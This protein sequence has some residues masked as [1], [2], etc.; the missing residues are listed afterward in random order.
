MAENGKIKTTIYQKC[1]KFGDL[2][3]LNL[4]FVVSCVPIITIGAATTAMYSFTTKLVKDVEGP[5]WKSYWSAFRK[6]FKAATKAWLVVLVILVAMFLEFMVSYSTAGLAYAF[7]LALMALEAVFLSFV[8][9]LLFPLIARYKNTTGNYFKNAFLLCISNIGSW[10]YLFFIWVLPIALC[11]ANTKIFYYSW[12]V[13][14]AL[15]IAVLAYASSMVVVKLYDKIESSDNYKSEV[16]KYDG[17]DVD[18]AD[19]KGQKSKKNEPA[20]ISEHL[21][22]CATSSSRVKAK[23]KK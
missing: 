20:R 22:N 2:F 7:L 17:E 14:L 3:I 21:N 1:E 13:W 8:L 10:F 15:L 18:D 12:P 19:N 23:N 9:P 16:K 11:A 6:N 4:L 5:I